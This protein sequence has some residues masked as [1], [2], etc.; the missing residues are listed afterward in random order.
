MKN[1]TSVKLLKMK[2]T[3]ST[4]VVLFVVMFLCSD[5]SFGLVDR[6]LQLNEIRPLTSV[7]KYTTKGRVLQETNAS[8]GEWSEWLDCSKTCGVGVKVRNKVPLNSES[9]PYC[10]KIIESSLCLVKECPVIINRDEEKK[11]KS[12]ALTYG[13]IIVAITI[14]NI[15]LLLISAIISINKKFI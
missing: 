2:S 12:K 4:I 11:K 15:V 13:A 7:N 1:V 8:C 14:V 9:E 3:I 10:S 6:S 5:F